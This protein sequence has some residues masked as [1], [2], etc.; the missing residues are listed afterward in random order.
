VGKAGR[1][2]HT[3]ISHR[4]GS[5]ENEEKTKYNFLACFSEYL[6]SR[7]GGDFYYTRWMVVEKIGCLLANFRRKIGFFFF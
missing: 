3:C 6:R 1:Y 4:G 7:N 5:A 2:T